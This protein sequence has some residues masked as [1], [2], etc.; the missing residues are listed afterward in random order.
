VINGVKVYNNTF[1]SGDQAGWYLVLITENMDRTNG[2]PSLGARLYNNIF[3]TKYKIPSI[4]I[5][6]QETFQDFECDYNIYYCEEGDHKPVFSIGDVEYTW[7]QWRALG[8]DSHSYVLNPDFINTTSF[9][10]RGRLDYGTDLGASWQTALSTS[11]VWTPGA[12]PATTN[13][14]G[15]W[16]VGA[17]IYTAVTSPPPV[18]PPG[19]ST[20]PETNSP[21]VIVVNAPAENLSGFVGEIDASGSY[22]NNNDRLTFT[23]ISPSGISV[24]STNTSK[25]KFL[26][27]VTSSIQTVEFTVKVS[28]GISTQIQA[29][30]VKILPYKPELESAEVVDVRASSFQS[31]HYPYDAVDGDIGTMWSANGDD[32]WLLLELNEPFNVQHVKIAFQPGQKKVS[33]FDVLGSSDGLTWETILTK[34]ASC[35]FSGDLHVF[36]F[37]PSK[38]SIGFKYIKYVGH[39][40]SLDSWNYLSEFRIFGYRFR[41]PDGSQDLAVRL[42]PNPAQDIINIR[43]DDSS[44]KPEFIRI[45]N[46]TGKI[47]FEEKIDPEMREFQIPVQFRQGIY[48]LQLG[49]KDLTL[50]TQKL[51]INA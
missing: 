22:D 41:N 51:I 24:S 5:D 23:W 35:G 45:L 21:P 11:A 2:A 18:T 13:Q 47:I 15:K 4:K 36:D 6:V 7:E 3:Y 48:I 12:A 30:P 40:N 27:P 10:P 34:S 33:Y 28:D 14:N 50:F 16:Q 38:A 25:I 29:V 8:Y 20:P 19:P 49:S 32:Q 46:L 39:S 44:I 26:T 42:Y 37:P 1:Y 43:I 31:P 17:V 9:V